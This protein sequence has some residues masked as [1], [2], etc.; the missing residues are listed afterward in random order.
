MLV[1]GC[2]SS[3]FGSQTVIKVHVLAPKSGIFKY[4]LASKVDIWHVLDIKRS[5]YCEFCHPT[6]TLAHILAPKR[7]LQS[8][9]SR[10]GEFPLT[11]IDG[12]WEP[13]LHES[14]SVSQSITK[15]GI[16]KL[17]FTKAGVCQHLCVL[18]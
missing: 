13:Q 7:A 8:M 12:H 18:Y 10:L 1:R 4:V 17:Y 11:Q 15:L 2:F 14:H 6:A 9:L 5:L 3:H 16:K